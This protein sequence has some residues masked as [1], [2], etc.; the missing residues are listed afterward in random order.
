MQANAW[1]KNISYYYKFHNVILFLYIMYSVLSSQMSHISP[2]AAHRG[3]PAFGG[4]PASLIGEKTL[5]FGIGCFWIVG[6]VFNR[7][8]PG[9]RGCPA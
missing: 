4:R 8:Y 1:L 6:A 2:A 3:L 5:Q 9:Y 7:E